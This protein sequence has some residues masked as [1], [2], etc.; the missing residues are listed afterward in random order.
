MKEEGFAD[1]PPSSGT[2]PCLHLDPEVYVAYVDHKRDSKCQVY[3][4]ANASVSNSDINE[5][6]I[7]CSSDFTLILAGNVLLH[8][9][10][11]PAGWP[12]VVW[13]QT[14]AQSDISRL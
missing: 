1:F 5:Y 2:L 8:Q 13:R 3:I 7:L 12:N 10:P 6:V 4:K 9:V 14:G 11:I